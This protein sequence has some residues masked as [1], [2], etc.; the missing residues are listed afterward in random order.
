MSKPIS[1]CEEIILDLEK[2]LT[3]EREKNTEA[4]EIIFT[5]LK[6]GAVLES[7]QGRMAAEIPNAAIQPR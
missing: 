4:L 7:R 2:K 5:L 6:R 1:P 3:A